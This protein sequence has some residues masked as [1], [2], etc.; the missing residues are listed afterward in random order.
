MKKY[1]TFVQRLAASILDAIVFLP[2]NFFLPL[3]FNINTEGSVSWSLF[4]NG[5]FLFYSIYAHAS[6]GYTLGKKW[7]NIKVVR[8][9]NE[10]ELIGFSNAF[11]RDSIAILFLL[12]E[13]M[14]IAKHM[15]D[16]ATGSIIVLLTSFGWLIAELITML[17]NP[18]RRSVHDFLAGSV[19]IDIAQ[20]EKW[21]GNF[22]AEKSPE[23]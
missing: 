17:L 1:Q 10:A 19:V 22:H 5:L 11:K 13:I 9:D 3:V 18:K 6:Y 21:Q 20:P 4:S 16:T 12:L 7:M 23:Q 8:N 2:I 15:D 14:L